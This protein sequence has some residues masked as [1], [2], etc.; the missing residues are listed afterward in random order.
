MQFVHRLVDVP[1]V[2]YRVVGVEFPDSKFPPVDE[3]T[4]S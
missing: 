3:G 2:D 1:G 4:G